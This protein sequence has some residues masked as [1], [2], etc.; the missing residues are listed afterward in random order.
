MLIGF[1]LFMWLLVVLIASWNVDYELLYCRSVCDYV[2]EMAIA[3]CVT[4]TMCDAP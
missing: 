2:G 4:Q 1:N 3:S